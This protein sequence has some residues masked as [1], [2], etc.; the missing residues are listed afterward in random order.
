M[1]TTP[2]NAKRPLAAVAVGNDSIFPI[3]VY[4]RGAKASLDA[5]APEDELLRPEAMEDLTVTI[6]NEDGCGM[7]IAPVAVTPHGGQLLIELSGEQTRACG[8]GTYRLD[9]SFNEP[10]ERYADGKRLV[11]LSRKLCRVVSPR[12]ASAQPSAE[13]RLEVSDFLQGAPGKDGAPGKNAYEW[14]K[15]EGLVDSPEQFLQL[16]RGQDGKDGKSVYQLAV[17]QG[18]T[19]SLEEWLASLVGAKG[20]PGVDGKDAYQLAQEAGY[21]GSRS[22]YLASLKGEKGDAGDPGKSAYQSYLDTT[23]DDPKLSEEQW[24]NQNDFIY[25]FIHLLIYGTSSPQR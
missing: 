15:D 10:N 12:E 8:V 1:T 3:V 4:R 20:D 18:Y 24:A 7:P 9:L 25:Q 21:L 13:V 6:T 19:G 23:T 2:T 5:P 14:A 16:L 11:T 17:Q 22:S